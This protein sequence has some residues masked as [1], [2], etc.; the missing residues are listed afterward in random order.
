MSENAG[1]LLRWIGARAD[2]EDL[3]GGVLGYS[4]EDIDRMIEAGAVE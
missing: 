4:D 3:A 1:R 2:N